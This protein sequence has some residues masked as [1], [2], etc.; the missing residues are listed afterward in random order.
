[1]RRLSGMKTLENG[2]VKARIRH[3]AF[4]RQMAR[5]GVFHAG[6]VHAG[7]GVNALSGMKTVQI[8]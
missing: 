3:V 2:A 7:C 8:Q 4:V 5:K 6:F 1:M